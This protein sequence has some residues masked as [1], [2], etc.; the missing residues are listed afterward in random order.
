M[1][2]PVNQFFA[3]TFHQI[4]SSTRAPIVTTGAWFR[5]FHSKSSLNGTAAGV[6]G[7]IR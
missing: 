5:N 6:V 7:I 4:V 2:G 1:P 3:E